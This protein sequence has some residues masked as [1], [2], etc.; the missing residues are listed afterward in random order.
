M[1][2]LVSA[3]TGF[4]T[5]SRQLW[6]TQLAPIR[7]PI[8]E[9]PAQVHST[10]VQKTGK[11]TFADQLLPERGL[12]QQ[13]ETNVSGP[14]CYNRSYGIVSRLSQN[15]PDLSSGNAPIVLKPIPST[16]AYQTKLLQSAYHS[17]ARNAERAGQ[18]DHV[19]S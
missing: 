11:L 3:T 18:D 9:H 10:H 15:L 5:S 6:P 12:S 4:A 17:F 13:T 14:V 1:N 16:T 8:A 7:V 2:T 19:P